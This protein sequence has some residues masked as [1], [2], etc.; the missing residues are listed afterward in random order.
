[1]E[2]NT[3]LSKIEALLDEKNTS[4]I[5]SLGE[6][7][8]FASAY[9]YE[10]DLLRKTEL[11]VIAIEYT[12]DMSYNKAE[13]EARGSDR[14]KAFLAKMSKAKLEE[15]LAINNHK[16]SMNLHSYLCS[17]LSLA[18]SQMKLR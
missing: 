18:Q 10:L 9:M 4:S 16:Q 15:E 1:M 13:A 2:I 8:A 7:R 12:K 14:Y 17:R 6:K 5:H 3:I 11:A